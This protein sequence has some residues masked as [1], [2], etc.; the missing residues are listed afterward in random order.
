MAT[1]TNL[2]VPL[3]ALRQLSVPPLAITDGSHDPEWIDLPCRGTYRYAKKPVLRLPMDAGTAATA[4]RWIR[5]RKVDDLGVTPAVLLLFVA[6]FLLGIWGRRAGS[7][8]YLA[9][10]LSYFVAIALAW[11]GGKTERSLTVRCHPEMVGRRG[12][13]IPGVPVAVAR[14]WTNRNVDVRIVAAIP[15]WRR[16]PTW[17][18]IAASG[19]SAAA[20]VGI[21]SVEAT[22]RQAGIDLAA[23]FT[24]TV[25]FA[26]AITFAVKAL[27]LG[28]VAFVRSN[29]NSQ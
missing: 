14:E 24:I 28:Y 13:Y 7:L 29:T 18:Y 15:K 19:L 3:G 23:V 8:A 25:L 2:F 4:R 17:V 6:G 9:A 11:W 10:L 12:I 22:D 16:Y 26:I 5:F 1:D 20:G 27:P 21:F